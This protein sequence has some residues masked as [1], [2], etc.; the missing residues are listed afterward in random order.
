MKQTAVIWLVEQIKSEQNQKA[1]SAS[2]W[3]KV[4][5]KAKQMEEQQL[6][7]FWLGGIEC[8]EDGGISF[9]EYYSR[10]YKTQ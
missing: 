3:I 7:E 1:L 6:F 10:N 8:A 9:D 4:I 5:E 2:D